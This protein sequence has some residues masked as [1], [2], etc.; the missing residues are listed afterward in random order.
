M[1][2]EKHRKTRRSIPK[3]P[4]HVGSC[5][6]LHWRLWSWV[7]RSE[8][9][10]WPCSWPQ[11]GDAWQTQ[12]QLFWSLKM[13]GSENH[14]T[15]LSL[16]HRDKPFLHLWTSESCRLCANKRRFFEAPNGFMLISI[17]GAQHCFAERPLC[18]ATIFWWASDLRESGDNFTGRIMDNKNNKNWILTHM[19]LTVPGDRTTFKASSSRVCLSEESPRASRASAQASSSGPLAIKMPETSRNLEWLY[20]WTL[21]TYDTYHERSTTPL[22][23]FKPEK[24][25]KKEHHDQIIYQI[26]PKSQGTE[27]TELEK[28]PLGTF[29]K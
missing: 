14:I 6:D 7:T 24:T 28:P 5:T 13:S 29:S 26:Y 23:T 8:T 18:S 4:K 25:R 9:C 15:R 20:M 2:G 1:K 19:T 21:W 12:N 22:G 16:T 17:A 3:R 27:L 11:W 10:P